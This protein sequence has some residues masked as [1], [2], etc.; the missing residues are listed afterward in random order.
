MVEVVENA[1]FFHQPRHE[2]VVAFVVLDA[3][4]EFP[5][6]R[7]QAERVVLGGPADVL[8]NLLDD[9]GSGFLLKDAAVSG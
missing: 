7:P 1:G 2:L 4:F 3:I 8:V 6:C 9:L 5:V